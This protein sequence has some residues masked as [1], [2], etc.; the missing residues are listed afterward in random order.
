MAAA[1][2]ALTRAT[3]PPFARALAAAVASTPAIR[4]AVVDVLRGKR[5]YLQNAST[6]LDS[7]VVGPWVV[8]GCF[9][10]QHAAAAAARS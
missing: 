10:L 1:G 9:A 3:D 4:N 2:V 5:F 6:S 7:H 8:I